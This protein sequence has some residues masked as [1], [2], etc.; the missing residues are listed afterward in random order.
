MA[1]LPVK[2]NELRAILS[3][4]IN[5]FWLYADDGETM[6]IAQANAAAA[7]FEAL[8]EFDMHIET[9]ASN[10][11]HCDQLSTY[12]ARMISHNRADSA[13]HSNLFSSALNELLEVAFRARHTD[14]ELQCKVLRSGNW[15]RI[16]LTFPCTEE[17]RT[18]FNGALAQ[19]S[20][21][22]ALERYLFSVSTDLAPSREVVLAELVLNYE[23]LISIEDAGAHRIR[24]IVDLPLEELVI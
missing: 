7:A 4:I 12:L 11:V 1:G 18:F 20:G 15:D 19:M 17:E 9:F 6:T 2:L 13:R 23:A 14:G 24:L 3:P 10:W 16:E 5:K 22:D 21:D 8:I